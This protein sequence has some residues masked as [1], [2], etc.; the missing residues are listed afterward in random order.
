M[1]TPLLD[2]NIR[3]FLTLLVAIVIGGLLLLSTGAPDQP[4]TKPVGKLVGVVEGQTNK[5]ALAA[6]DARLKRQPSDEARLNV[7]A[8]EACAVIIAM[9]DNHPNRNYTPEEEPVLWRRY[10]R[11]ELRFR[12]RQPKDPD[13]DFAR[14]R[15]EYC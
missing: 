6:I 7:L 14:R 13:N 5:Q 10:D 15:N 4:S 3:P 2:R 12:K 11:L 1:S 9:Q 8:E